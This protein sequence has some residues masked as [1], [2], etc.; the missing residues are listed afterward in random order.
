MR[1]SLSKIIF[2]TKKQKKK[3]AIL[4]RRTG[5]KPK[6]NGIS[7]EGWQG[8]HTTTLRS[9]LLPCHYA[10]SFWLGGAVAVRFIFATFLFFFNPFQSK[11]GYKKHVWDKYWVFLVCFPLSVQNFLNVKGLCEENLKC[12]EDCFPF[13][14]CQYE[15]NTAT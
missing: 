2:K 10:V 13:T 3:K 15:P 7:P 1:N 5:E 14:L 4:T 8:N 11:K 12:F 6:G 9:H